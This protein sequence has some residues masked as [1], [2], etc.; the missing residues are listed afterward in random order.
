M[1]LDQEGSRIFW[2]VMQTAVQT[3]HRCNPSLLCKIGNDIFLLGFH[4]NPINAFGLKQTTNSWYTFI[5]FCSTQQAEEKKKLRGRRSN[6]AMLVR[7]SPPAEVLCFDRGT[8]PPEHSDQHLQPLADPMLVFSCP[9]HVGQRVV[10]T[11]RMLSGFCWTNSFWPIFGL[12]V[13]SIRASML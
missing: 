2:L 3:W 9:A 7:R 6:Y 8:G 10:H 5:F 4:V 13:P 12:C 1:S 11:G